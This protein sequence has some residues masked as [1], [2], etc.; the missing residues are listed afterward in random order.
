MTLPEDFEALWETITL[1]SLELPAGEKAII[2][3]QLP[4][5]F[6][7]VF[8][9]ITHTAQF[10]DVKGEPTKERQAFTLIFEN[11]PRRSMRRSRCGPGR[12]G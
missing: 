8:D 3:L 1:E 10:I 6:I 5:K 9:P 2:S 11:E 12:S 7:I 4:A